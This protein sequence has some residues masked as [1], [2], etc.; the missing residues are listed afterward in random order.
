MKD[1]Y[2]I[3]LDEIGR[4]A[5][6]GLKNLLN[7]LCHIHRSKNFILLLIPDWNLIFFEILLNVGKNFKTPITLL[8]TTPVFGSLAPLENVDAKVDE[9]LSS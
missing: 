9:Q 5:A 6:G 7:T 8:L 2:V 3:E 4:K 1:F